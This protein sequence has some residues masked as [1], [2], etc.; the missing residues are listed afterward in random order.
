MEEFL[1]FNPFEIDTEEYCLYEQAKVCESGI[2]VLK[3][4]KSE[5]A[6]AMKDSLKKERD[7]YLEL[8]ENGE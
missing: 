7:Y 4:D 1:D 5:E 2:M 6:E 3:E 8:I